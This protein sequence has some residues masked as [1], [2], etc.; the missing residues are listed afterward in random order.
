ML[1]LLNLVIVYSIGFQDKE[2]ACFLL[3]NGALRY[4]AG[5]LENFVELN[6]E[7]DKRK[8]LRRVV[9]DVFYYCVKKINEDEVRRIGL[10]QPS[11]LSIYRRLFLINLDYNKFTDLENSEKFLKARRTINKRIGFE[12]EKLKSRDL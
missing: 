11:D 8:L 9:E 10:K 1:F 6:L 12:T 5:E 4:R 2:N 3:A 7:I